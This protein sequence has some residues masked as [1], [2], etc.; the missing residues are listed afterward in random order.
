MAREDWSGSIRG[1]V[2]GGDMDIIRLAIYPPS[3]SGHDNT[4]FAGQTFGHF[5]PLSETGVDLHM[6]IYCVKTWEAFQYIATFFPDSFLSSESKCA[7][8]LAHHTELGNI[9][10]VRHL[11]DAGADINGGG[12]RTNENPLIIASRYGHEDIVDLLLER[13]A[14][15]EYSRLQASGSPLA[16]AASGGSMNIVRKLLDHGASPEGS[17]WEPLYTAIR[18]EHTAMVK[19]FV[20]LGSWTGRERE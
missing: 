18:L 13:G 12:E 1:A 16:A 17:G 5:D 14:D 2:M 19:L 11:L 9:D 6:S 15:P 7:R 3:R 4:E 8:L 20:N 10:M